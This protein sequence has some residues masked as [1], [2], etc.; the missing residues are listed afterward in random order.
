MATFAACMWKESL[1]LVKSQFNIDT[2][3]PQQEDDIR[4]FM[5]K[6]NLFVNLPRDLVAQV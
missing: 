3:L 1:S 2:L 5:E 4:A 6:G